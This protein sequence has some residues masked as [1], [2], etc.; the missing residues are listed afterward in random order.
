MSLA[1]CVN[2]D[3]SL[4]MFTSDFGN[5]R[6]GQQF[7]P[8][9]GITLKNIFYCLLSTESYHFE[10]KQSEDWRFSNS[11]ELSDHILETAG[12][13]NIIRGKISLFDKLNLT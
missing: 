6:F 8:I 13:L 1:F 9:V 5:T 4:F 12:K 7:L 2:T 3:P 10:L 11:E